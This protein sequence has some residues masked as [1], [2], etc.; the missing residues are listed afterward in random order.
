[1]PKRDDEYL[2]QL[3]F[4]FEESDE[5]NF[6]IGG[7]SGQNADE[8]KEEYHVHLACD[9]GIMCQQGDVMFRLTSQGHDY[10]ASIR[11]ETIWKKTMDGAASIGGASL[12]V[13]KDL[14]LVYVK[15]ELKERLGVDL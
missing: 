1:M 15:Q 12:G 7:V 4:K 14:A 10:I 5:Y 9:A 8:L 6:L 13:M 11:S 2:R 3:L